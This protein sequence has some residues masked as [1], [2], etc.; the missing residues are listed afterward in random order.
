[1]NERMIKMQRRRIFM[2]LVL[3][4]AVLIG[5]TSVMLA[6]VGMENIKVVYRNIKLKVNGVNVPIAPG[7]EP[8]IYQGRTYVPLRVVSEALGHKVTWDGANFTVLIGDAPGDTFLSELRP[9]HLENMHS[10]NLLYNAAGNMT[11]AGIKYHSGIQLFR[12]FWP[13]MGGASEA[14]FNLDAKYSSLTGLVGL[15]DNHHRVP[16]AVSFYG[17]DRLLATVN[18]TP[19]EPKPKPVDINIKGVLVLKIVF[20]GTPDGA[21]IN[22]AN[23]INLANM[24]LKK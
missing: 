7:N 9:F 22:R 18:L 24:T 19:Q 13:G 11:M 5:S 2:A 1:M 14:H 15:D 16:M 17:D 20:D 6:R 23:G 21:G 4:V 3:I 8:F 12:Y 10:G